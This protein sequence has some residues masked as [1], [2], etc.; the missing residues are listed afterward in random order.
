MLFSFIYVHV[1]A[2]VDPKPLVHTNFA[3][4]CTF[5]STTP[6]V[7]ILPVI[8]LLERTLSFNYSVVVL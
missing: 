4:Q 8:M 7:Y 3:M 2:F 1:L 6:M 5:H